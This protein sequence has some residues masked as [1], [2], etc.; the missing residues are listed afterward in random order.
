MNITKENIHK[1]E[2]KNVTIDDIR[3]IKDEE[4]RDLAR[5]LR[6]EWLVKERKADIE[7][8][9]KAEEETEYEEEERDEEDFIKE[10]E[11]ENQFENW[12]GN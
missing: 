11:K 3:A 12:R 4:L 2:W 10:Q 1:I 9:L 8:F 7:R 5:T 6:A